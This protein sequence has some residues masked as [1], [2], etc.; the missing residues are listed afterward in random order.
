MERNCCQ[1]QKDGTGAI[2][3]ACQRALPKPESH[4]SSEAIDLLTTDTDTFIS[5]SIKYR[6]SLPVYGAFREIM[7]FWVAIRHAFVFTE[8][9][10]VIKT[11]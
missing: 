7:W 11:R 4:I 1:G 2:F 9:S 8:Q 5:L 3:R 6:L 10:L